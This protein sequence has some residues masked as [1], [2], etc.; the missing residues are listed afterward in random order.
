MESQKLEPLDPTSQLLSSRMVVLLF[1]EAWS[2]SRMGRGWLLVVLA[3]FIQSLLLATDLHLMI[4]FSTSSYEAI[5][6]DTWLIS[7]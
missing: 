2:F 5:D 7:S 1:I 3:L 4:M 6:L